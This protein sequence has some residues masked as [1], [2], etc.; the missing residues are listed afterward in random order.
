[1]EDVLT[2]IKLCRNALSEVIATYDLKDFEAE[3]KQSKKND[4][5][6]IEKSVTERIS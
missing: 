4:R 1:M 3:K 2:Y 6:Y 5:N